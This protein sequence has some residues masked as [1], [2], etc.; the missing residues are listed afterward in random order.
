MTINSQFSVALHILTLLAHDSDSWL[1][2][3][4]IASSVNT[5]PALVRKLL[6][7]LKKHGFIETRHGLTGGVQLLKSAGEI[8][9]DQVFNAVIEGGI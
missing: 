9:L 6:S 5:N 1:S 2:S 3:T 4:S 8:R 7:K